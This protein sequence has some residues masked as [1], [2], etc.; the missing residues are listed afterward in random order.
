MRGRTRAI[1]DVLGI[2]QIG[3]L[4]DPNPYRLAS[5]SEGFIR[6]YTNGIDDCHACQQ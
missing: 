1:S 4:D 5:P 3:S 2:S 6:D